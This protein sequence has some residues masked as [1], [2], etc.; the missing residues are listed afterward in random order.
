MRRWRQQPQRRGL[1]ETSENQAV[2][3]PAAK[4]TRRATD[5]AASLLCSRCAPRGARARR[6]SYAARG[7]MDGDGS[8]AKFIG[9]EYNSSH[10]QEADHALGG[11]RT[12]H[13]VRLYSA[14]DDGE[15]Q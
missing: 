2:I 8:A 4:T 10:S 11:F 7:L 12:L 9:A 15:R 13:G 6:D 3:A 14:C 5:T 1:C